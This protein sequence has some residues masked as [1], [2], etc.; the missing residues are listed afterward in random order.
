M[1]RKEKLEKI[2][3]LLIEAKKIAKTI[4]DDYGRTGVIAMRF[5][6][7]PNDDRANHDIEIHIVEDP[8]LDGEL[9]VVKEESIDSEILYKKL[10]AEINGAYVFAL[11]T[12]EE[13]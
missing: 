4:T 13:K 3:N 12:E 1:N 2:V 8:F 11:T 10:Y 9:E 6:S 5:S 7:C